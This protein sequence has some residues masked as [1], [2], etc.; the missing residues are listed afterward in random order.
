MLEV[1]RC[2][3]LCSLEVL[4]GAGGDE[5]CATLYAGGCGAY[6]L[7]FGVLEVPEVYA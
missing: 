1:M 2:V 3:L 7:F 6:G 4:G 5:L